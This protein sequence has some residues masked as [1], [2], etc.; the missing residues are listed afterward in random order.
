MLAR[1]G[2][3]QSIATL[4]T[5]GVSPWVSTAGLFYFNSKTLR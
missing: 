4:R 5:V 1:L 3:Q 2:A